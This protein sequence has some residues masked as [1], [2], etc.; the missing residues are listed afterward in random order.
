MSLVSRLVALERSRRVGGHTEAEVR[1]RC[2]QLARHFDLPFQDVYEMTVHI[3]TIGLDAAL[4]EAAAERGVSVEE[5]RREADAI[6][7]EFP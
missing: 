2:D 4:Q 5:V 3:L 6:V 1:A 7:T